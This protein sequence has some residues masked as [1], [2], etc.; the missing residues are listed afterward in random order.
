LLNPKPHAGAGVVAE[1]FNMG[2]EIKTCQFRHQDFHAFERV[3]AAEMALLHE[4][5]HDGRF[6]GHATVAGI[7]LEAWLVGQDRQPEPRNEEFI[8]RLNSPSVVPELSQFNV[9]FNVD[10]QPLTGDGL[11]RLDRDLADS[12]KRAS[13]VAEELGMALMCIGI[14]PT[15]DSGSLTVDTMSEMVRYRALN[16]QILRMRRGRPLRLEIHGEDR[17]S[18]DHYDVMLEAA[19]TSLQIH[20]QIPIERSVRFYNASLIVSPVMVAISANSPFL[21]GRR[22]WA[23]TRIPLFEQS[24][25]DGALF[26]RVSFGRGYAYESLEEVFLENRSCHP[27]LL[28]MVLDEPPER[29]PHVRLHNGTIWRW[30]RPLIG[31]D[32]QGTPHLR[33]EHRTMP[34][35]PTLADMSANI[36]FYFGLVHSLASAETPP[37]TIIPFEHVLSS[38]KAA[39]KHGLK[40]T[41]AWIDRSH[42]EIPELILN[43]LIELARAGLEDLGIDAKDI[44]QALE[45]ISR[46]AETGRNGAAWQRAFVERHGPDMKAL[47]SAYLERQIAGDPVHTW[48]V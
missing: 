48:D 19:T 7:E 10:P 8:K 26:P 15:I 39:A 5:F 17:L 43:D 16:E 21:F 1:G 46:R 29:F 42:R 30:N 22:L 25:D 3:L 24:V 33:I 32:E 31:F 40:A 6:D 47:T 27:V 14:L 34:S 37:E 41:I 12:W 4:M 20:L 11:A 36:A 9:E 35:G 28:P 23:E 13:T 2:Q 45:I 38:F 18:T 44:D